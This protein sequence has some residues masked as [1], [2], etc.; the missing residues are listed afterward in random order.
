MNEPS[1]LM[2][3]IPTPIQ[4]DTHTGDPEAETIRLAQLDPSHFQS[5]YD[6]WV[7]PVYAYLLSQT[8]SRADAEDLTS[9][10]FLSAY[11]AL[12]RY[13]HD[14]RFAGWLFTIARNQARAFFRKRGREVPLGKVEEL[15]VPSD[16]L[17]RTVSRAQLQNLRSLVDELAQNE[18]ELIRLRYVADLSFADM[19][20]VLGRSE[21]A[22]KKSLYRLQDRL[23]NLLEVS[24]D[25]Q[26]L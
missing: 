1:L 26:P 8:G 24:D 15:S 14:G 7:A 11:Q 13:R 6:R 23:E 25:E 22:V 18:R 5:L 19:A 9:Q 2:K 10:V 20:A 21:E 12:P 16:L 17:E 3:T 4:P